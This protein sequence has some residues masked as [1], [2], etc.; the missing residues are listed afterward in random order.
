MFPLDEIILV[1]WW[2]I[3][4]QII[5]LSL[6]KEAV[7]AV[8]WRILYFN[9]IVLYFTVLLH[10]QQYF[11]LHLGKVFNCFLSSFHFQFLVSLN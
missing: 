3:D 10:L 9:C 4:I 8:V 2:Y 5:I 11:F 7:V 1:Q 6:K